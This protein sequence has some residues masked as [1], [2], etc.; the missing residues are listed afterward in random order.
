MTRKNMNRYDVNA[1]RNGN[2][3]FAC[4]SSPSWRLG[5]LVVV[6]F[7]VSGCSALMPPRHEVEEPRRAPPALAANP[8]P[9]AASAMPATAPQGWGTYQVQPGDTIYALARRHRVKPTE[10]AAANGLVADAPLKAGQSVR[11]PS[12]APALARDSAPAPLAAPRVA[13]AKAELAPPP[14]V[15]PLRAQPESIRATPVSAPSGRLLPAPRR[16]PAEAPLQGAAAPPVDD[17]VELS[18]GP[19][20]ESE[21]P[22]P[23]QQVA[24][25]PAPPPEP[26]APPAPEPQAKPAAAP[27][28]ARPAARVPDPPARSASGFLRPLEGRVLAS[29]GAQ[30]GGLR[31]DG[32]NIAATR[33][34]PVRAA[35]NGVV[36]YA[37]NELRGFGNLLLISHDGGWMTVY[38]HLDSMGVARGDK[39]ARGQRIGAVGMTG[40]VT[41]PQL[42]F[43]IRKG[44]QPVDPEPQLAAGAP[45]AAARPPPVGAAR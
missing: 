12:E 2:A 11:V 19:A 28:P 4:G 15:E 26:A 3:A 39:I 43:E 40:N 14:R 24:A 18:A 38:A 30:P 5:A 13:V 31:N 17:S 44:K 34:A 36:V 20:L 27:E 35:E 23:A 41:S 22:P 32:I 10:I 9:Q 25:L 16:A 33:G 7:A 6:A 37:G 1:R 45:Q 42:H 29:F 8:A 21:I